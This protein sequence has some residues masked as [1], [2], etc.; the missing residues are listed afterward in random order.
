MAVAW[1]YMLWAQQKTKNK[2]QKLTQVELSEF[3]VCRQCK[4]IHLGR[5]FPITKK[6][7][8]L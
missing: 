6:I 2:K 8:F 7:F 1:V 3:K 4:N 5:K